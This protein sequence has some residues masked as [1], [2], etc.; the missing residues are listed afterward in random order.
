MSQIPSKLL[1]GHVSIY[2]FDPAAQSDWSVLDASLLNAAIAGGY[3]F[4]ISC[5]V[6]SGY[7]L[8]TTGFASD[9]STSVCDI[10]NVENPTYIEYSASLDG[11][12]SDPDD[13][14]AVYDLFYDL[15]SGI[16]RDFY[17]VSRIGPAQ[18][19]AIAAGQIMSAFGLSTDYGTDIVADNEMLL[20][21]ARFKP[22]GQINTFATVQA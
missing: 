12:R 15:F 11:F 13:P 7:E 10:G 2:A 21:G 17:L 20:W 6:E 3:G 14:T 5:A 9:D 18:G 16:D 1:A 19:T 4:D 8:G 22:T